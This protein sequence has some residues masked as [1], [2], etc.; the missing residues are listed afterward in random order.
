MGQA[1]SLYGERVLRHLPRVLP[2]EG[3]R[4]V[5]ADAEH[6]M[7]KVT[8]QIAFE[9]GGWSPERRGKVA[10]LFDDLADTW[11]ER[12]VATRRDAFEDAL[13]RG[14]PFPAGPCLELGAGV[15]V[16]TAGLAARFE[17]VVAVDLSFEMLRRASGAVAPRLLADSAALPFA[18]RSAG[19]VV[20]VNMFLFPDEVE[21]VLGPD[22]VV[23]WVS[24][25]GDGTPIY[26]PAEEVEA[27]LPG[28]WDGVA[29]EAG[30]GT[31]AVF[32][33]ASATG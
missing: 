25:V 16:F 1:P 4:P 11:H 20:L 10:A 15:G 26:L 5:L 23:V 12:H 8:R 9:P 13:T 3:E 21:R 33:R 30:W 28:T 27:A 6:P 29:S 18:S 7:R 24:T 17:R 19:A 14:G 22:G 2:A 31:W 32:R